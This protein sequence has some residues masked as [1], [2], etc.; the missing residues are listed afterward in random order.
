MTYRLIQGCIANCDLQ[1]KNLAVRDR[2]P[3]GRYM[4][5]PDKPT[6]E[7][8]A[9]SLAPAIGITEVE[10][11]AER[12]KSA[13]MHISQVQQGNMTQDQ[14]AFEKSRLMEQVRKNQLSAVRASMADT[15]M[16]R[17]AESRFIPY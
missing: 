11:I 1:I 17:S 2:F 13:L 6:V 3:G 7:W 5:L 16:R 4:P 10:G 12:L 8:Y 15:V 9:K 14:S